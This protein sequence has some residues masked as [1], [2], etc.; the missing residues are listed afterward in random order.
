M[1]VAEKVREMSLVGLGE[2]TLV[3][4]CLW[5]SHSKEMQVFSRN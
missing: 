2:S 5:G 3:V 4:N 1:L